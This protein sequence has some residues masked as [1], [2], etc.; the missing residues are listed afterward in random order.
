MVIY[1]TM[2]TLTPFG[3]NDFIPAEASTY[4]A[5]INKVETQFKKQGY[6][7][8]ITP[9]I[10]Y[11]DSLLPGMGES[12]KESSI[13]F[14]DGSGQMLLMRPDHTTPIARMVANRMKSEKL[15]LRLY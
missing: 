15:P 14:F 7:Q 11:Y 10:E 6:E 4:S 8:V 12:L 1:C 5:I 3:V 9:T 13:K 2:K